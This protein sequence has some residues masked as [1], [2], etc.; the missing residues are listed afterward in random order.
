M[1]HQNQNAKLDL[2]TSAGIFLGYPA[3]DKNGLYGDS[4][5]GCFKTAT[6]VVFDK[7]GMTLPATERNPAAK[8]LQE[9]GYRKQFDD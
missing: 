1:H 5:T 7:A 4:V 8:V 9:L 3:T 2:N 6:H